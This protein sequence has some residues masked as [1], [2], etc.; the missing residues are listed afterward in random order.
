MI[1]FFRKIRKMLVEQNKISRYLAYAL[2]EILLVVIGI[3]LAVQVNDWNEGR[4][5]QRIVASNNAILIENLEADFELIESV[6]LKIDSERTQLNQFIERINGPAANLDTLLKIRQDE[7]RGAVSGIRFPNDDAYN[8]MVLSN[9]VNLFNNELKKM[10]F[11]VYNW[12]ERI[13]ATYTREFEKY[14]EARKFLL[15]KYPST[16]NLY[17]GPIYESVWR[18]VDLNDLTLRFLLVVQ[19]KR[20][21]YGLIYSNLETLKGLTTELIKSLKTMG[22]HD[23]SF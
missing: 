21:M 1:S 2:G 18:N 4:K 12:H 9:E 13:D 20:V 14:L 6:L 23:K 8:T 10:L 5:T 11:S 3:F 19:R 7:L 16:N 17:S 22:D 15:E